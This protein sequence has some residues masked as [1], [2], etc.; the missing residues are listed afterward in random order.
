MNTND[1]SFYIYTSYG[2][3]FLVLATAVLWPLLQHRRIL[4]DLKRMQHRQAQLEKR[5]S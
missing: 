2:I 4:R 1:Y 3:S 5:R